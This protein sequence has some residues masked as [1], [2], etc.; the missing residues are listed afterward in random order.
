MADALPGTTVTGRRGQPV[1]SL[2]VGTGLSE[3]KSAARRTLKEGGVSLNNHKITGEAPWSPQDDLL[4]GRFV[5]LR[6]GENL[7]AVTFHGL[8]PAGPVPGQGESSLSGFRRRREERRP[9]PPA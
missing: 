5:L 7:A 8:V 4:H 2:L 1:V 3:S 6:R 9:L